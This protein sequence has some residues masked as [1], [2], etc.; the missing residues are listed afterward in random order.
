MRSSCFLQTLP[1]ARRS[2]AKVQLSQTQPFIAARTKRLWALCSV[3]LCAFLAG[4]TNMKCASLLKIQRCSQGG[5]SFVSDALP[6]GSTCEMAAGG[7]HTAKQLTALGFS[8]HLPCKPG[9]EAEHQEKDLGSDMYPAAVRDYVEQDN[10]LD[11]R[12]HACRATR[13]RHTSEEKKRL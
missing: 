9:V 2:R 4:T 11:L 8:G 7:F 6:M 3:V 13:D 10:K 12:C 5:T 1:T